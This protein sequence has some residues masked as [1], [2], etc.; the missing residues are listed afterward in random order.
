MVATSEVDWRTWGEQPPPPDRFRPEDGDDSSC[1]S[2]ARQVW[3][4][5]HRIW[6]FNPTATNGGR[7]YQHFGGPYT[8][9]LTPPLFAAH[10]PPTHGYLGAV[11]PL[12]HSLRSSMGHH[13]G[14]S[15]RE[16]GGLPREWL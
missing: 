6:A 3:V 13:R 9:H 15:A 2:K 8:D 4:A 12:I 10:E 1:N 5:H 11:Q 16:G 14:L 7:K